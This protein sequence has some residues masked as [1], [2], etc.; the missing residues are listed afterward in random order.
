[1][2]EPTFLILTA[3]AT[4]PRHGYGIIQEVTV[5]SDRRVTLLPGTLYTA[6]DRLTAQGLVEPDREEVVDGR[7]RRYYRLTPG[8]LAALESETARLRQLA[9]AA[10][11][12]LRALRPRTT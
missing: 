7:L 4:G 3:L 10:E 12:R 9:T 11:T 8:G 5:L 1:M 6:L 2:R